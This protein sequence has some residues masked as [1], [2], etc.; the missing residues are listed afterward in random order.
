M[1]ILDLKIRRNKM[2]STN[3]IGNNWKDVR[4]ELF[5]QEEIHKNDERVV[6]I[7]KIIEKQKKEEQEKN[8][9]ISVKGNT[10]I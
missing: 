4:K 1:G 3:A 7:S 8:L 2:N 9:E 5:I 10:G 6:K